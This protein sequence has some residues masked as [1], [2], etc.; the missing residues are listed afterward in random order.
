MS[1]F[2]YKLADR[3]VNQSRERD[4]GAMLTLHDSISCTSVV[5][6]K[7]PGRQQTIRSELLCVRRLHKANRN[8]ENVF[9][10]PADTDGND[11]GAAGE[12]FLVFRFVMGIA[13]Q[14]KKGREERDKCRITQQTAR[15]YKANI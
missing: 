5:D 15:R 7:P 1:H 4:F 3:V 12:K 14:P 6:R 8:T 9:I 13:L 11:S 2:G 10:I